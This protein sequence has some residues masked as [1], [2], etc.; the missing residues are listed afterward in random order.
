MIVFMDRLR[1]DARVT[2]L[3]GIKVLLLIEGMQFV[4]FNVLFTK[5]QI[6]NIV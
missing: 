5:T 2:C 3:V 4:H 6:V 1:H